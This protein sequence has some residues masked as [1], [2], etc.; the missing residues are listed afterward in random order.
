[1][2]LELLKEAQIVFPKIADVIDAISQHG[3]PLW[4]ETEGK[5]GIY[6]RVIATVCKNHRVNHAAASNFQPASAANITSLAAAQ[7]TFDIELRARLGE[8]KK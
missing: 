2:L 4:S 3:N 6:F 5:T 7:E 8:R 1:M